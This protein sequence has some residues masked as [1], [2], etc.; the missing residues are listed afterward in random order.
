MYI[1]P[2]ITKEV[3]EK[4]AK[5]IYTWVKEHDL[6]DDLIIYYNHKRID[7]INYKYK[8]EDNI[9]VKDYCE[10]APNHH[11]LT[12]ASEGMLYDLYNL[13]YEFPMELRKIWEDLGLYSE[14]NE[15]WNWSL[16]PLECDE[17]YA[18]PFEYDD[19][20][21]EEE[22]HIYYNCKDKAPIELANIMEYW[23]NASKAVGDIGSCVI[24]SGFKFRWKDK[25]WFMSKC[26]PYQGCISW[27][28][29]VV[30]IKNL[31]ESIGATEIN[32]HYGTLD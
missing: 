13:D 25:L 15:S 20:T 10:Y 21:P 27:E 5:D 8:E 28:A 4:L 22:H 24:G 17:C 19:Y 31:L 11:I 9:S 26:S 3:I 1:Y 14:A 18:G 12:I 7:V 30:A 6:D 23:Y 2:A 29:H 32:Y 16:S